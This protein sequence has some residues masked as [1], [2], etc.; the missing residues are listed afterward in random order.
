M[1]ASPRAWTA[2]RCSAPARSPAISSVRGA[3]A[4]RAPLPVRRGGCSPAPTPTASRAPRRAARQGGRYALTNGRGAA[5]TEP[6]ALSRAPF[7]VAVDLDDA[8]RDAR[9]RLAAPL[10]AADLY[11]DF[12]GQIQRREEVSWNAREGAV[13]ARRTVSLEALVLEDSP[14]PEVQAEAALA[15]MLAGVREMGLA[16]LPWDGAARELRA[17]LAF[18]RAAAGEGGGAWPEVSDAAL[19]AE[20]PAWLGPYLGGITRR[21]ELARVPLHEA[22]AARLD[23]A[24]RRELAQLAPTHLPLPGGSRVKVEYEGPQ[25]PVVS[26]RLQEVFGLAVTPRLGRAQVPVTFNLLSPAQ[27]P[28][29]VTRD[30]ASFWRGA[31]AQV[32]RDMRGRYPKHDWPEDPL[33]AQPSRGARRRR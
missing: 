17:R 28:L 7:L 5:F 25:A 26:V 24:Q 20:L 32:R 3:L 30:L 18:V 10:E 23:P 2:V 4:R 11:R 29:Q 6:Q 16:A 27:R 8:E 14:L 1:T 22:L 21:A 31:Y 12:A 15:A 9:I 33:A 13:T 19:M